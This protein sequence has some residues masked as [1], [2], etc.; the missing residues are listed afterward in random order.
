MGSRV[1]NPETAVVEKDAEENFKPLEYEYETQV[2]RFSPKAFID[3]LFNCVWGAVQGKLSTMKE[4]I[5]KQ[6]SRVLS[7]EEIEEIIGSIEVEMLRETQLRFGKLETFALDNIF[8]IPPYGCLPED[9]IQTDPRLK[10]VKKSELDK[11]ISELQ[12][13]AD[14]ARVMNE[15]LTAELDAI[16]EARANQ[17]ESLECLEKALEFGKD[18]AQKRHVDEDGVK[19]LMALVGGETDAAEE[20]N[21]ENEDKSTP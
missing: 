21:D 19:T 16:K 10:K 14:R 11:E 8:A 1:E 17:N 4:E 12:K 2:F 7:Q 9:E 20:E 13:R 3:S 18:L 15:L 6:Y 5:L